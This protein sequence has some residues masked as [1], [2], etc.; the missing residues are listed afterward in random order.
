MAVTKADVLRVAKQY[1]NPANLTTVV[2]GNPMVFSE[3]LEKL[4]PQINRI[5]LTIREAKAHTLETS[6]AS[7]AEGK[8]LLGRAQAAIGG[9]DKLAAVKDYIIVADYLVDP[10]VRRLEDPKSQTDRWIG[11]HQFP[12]GSVAADRRVPRTQMASGWIST[13][14]GRRCSGSS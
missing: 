3:P 10:A 8:R 2:V 5:D 4:N 7:L 11:P 6:D 9:V 13:P 14:R 1:L 12:A